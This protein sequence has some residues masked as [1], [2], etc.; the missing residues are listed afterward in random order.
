MRSVLRG[1]LR[2]VASYPSLALEMD[3]LFETQLTQACTL[4]AARGEPIG[5]FTRIAHLRCLW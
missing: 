1:T 4:S 2:A 5:R 3:E